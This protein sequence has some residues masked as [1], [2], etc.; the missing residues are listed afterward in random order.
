M[1]TRAKSG[2]FKPKQLHHTSKFVPDYLNIEPPTFKVAT[3][4]PQWHDAMLHEFQA[5]HRQDTW[6]L[7]PPQS[8][9]NLVGCRWVYKLKR[10]SDG[11]IARYK[12]RLVAKG[13]H[14]QQGLDY[15]ETFS[16]VVKPAT[17]RLVLSIAAQ[18]SWP[19]RQLDVSNAFLHGFLKETVYMEQPPGFIDS[20]LPHHV[21]KLKKA[22][23]GLKQ[24][25]RAWFERFTTHLL[26]LGFHSSLV[27]PSLFL[28]RHGDNV[29]FLLLYVD[30]IIVTG[31]HPMAVQSLL[32]QL[33]KE[34]DIKDLGPLKFF[35][36]LQIEYQSS[37]FFVH[38]HKYA[39]DLLQ[40]FNMTTCKPCRT[41]FVSL[42]R[43][44]KDDGVPLQD[45]TP[46]RSMVG[47]LQY[48]TFTRPDLA[49]AVNHICQFMHQPTDQHLVAAKRILRYVQGSLHHGLTFRPGPLTL[50]AY[51][52]S[53][54]A[55]D[56]MDRRST[57]GLIIF[58][59]HNPITWQS[60][61]QPTV[62]RSS[63]EAEYRALANC[64]AD[65]SWVRMVL[66]DLGVFLCHPPTIWCDNLSALALATNPVFH[67]RTKHVEV[68]YH[69]IRE[70]VTNKDIQLHHIST[71]DQLADLLTKALSSPY[72]IYIYR[73]TIR[74]SIKL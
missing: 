67:A 2:I 66:Q 48:L 55:G 52:D 64:T 43:L 1:Q 22:L 63:T 42:S 11:T 26:T 58:L 23:Y 5:L 44:R 15:E 59:G 62:S 4:Y 9:Q 37:G 50:T 47:G 38:Q 25:P 17:V 7:V 61:K 41:P 24:A 34:F 19:L 18:Q 69:F 20:T 21:C 74:F 27:D 16:P 30:E 10:H 53:D 32:A 40:K 29:M 73:T 6:E 12:A 13:Y 71:E 65:L 45:P 39:S 36:G 72:I 31:N 51:T 60:K 54:W 3:Q 14:Q 8:N 35:L 28:Y 56:P 46:F 57:T 49:Y 68:D 33:S 70:K